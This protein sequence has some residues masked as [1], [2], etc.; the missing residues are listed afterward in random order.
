[1]SDQMQLNHLQREV[2][3]ALELAL[4][5]LAPTALLDQLAIAAGMLDAL[6]DLELA[7]ATRFPLVARIRERAD[8]ALADWRS[9]QAQHPPKAHA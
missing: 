8:R 1:M 3:T 4:V 9:W 5:A 6:R 7:D 2:K